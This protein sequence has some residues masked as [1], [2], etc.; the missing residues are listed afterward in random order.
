M[1]EVINVTSGDRGLVSPADGG[2][3]SIKLG[4]GGTLSSAIGGDSCKV[5]GSLLIEGQNLIKELFVKY[6]MSSILKPLFPGSFWQNSDAIQ[7]FS[8][9]NGGRK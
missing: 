2:N 7:D 1:S 9:G 3:L 8:L 5:S 4:D 6:G